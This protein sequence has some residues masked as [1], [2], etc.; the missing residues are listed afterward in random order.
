MKRFERT[1]LLLES[2]LPPL[3]QRMRRDLRRLAAAAGGTPEILDVGGRKSHCTIGV[4]GWITVSDL[5]RETAVQ[6]Q[7]NLGVTPEMASLLLENRSNV[8]AV[9]F[10]DMARSTL[11]DEA[12]DCVMAIEVLEHVEEDDRFVAHARR[13]LKPGGWF[14]MSTPNGD[15]LPNRNPD[16]KR[17][18]TREQLAALL[19]NHF[20]EVEVEY[21]IAGGR[22]RRLG[23]HAWSPRRPLQTAMSMFG[24]VVNRLQSADA[25]LRDQARGTHH[26]IARARKRD[27]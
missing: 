16:H 26:L 5:P 7:L 3:H 6:K 4:P 13:V 20:E 24:N 25:R 12:F 19:A 11:P 15:F 27:G 9:V 22:Y 8:R 2:L 14:L 23:L 1:Y 17:H 21:A 10:D 18:Y